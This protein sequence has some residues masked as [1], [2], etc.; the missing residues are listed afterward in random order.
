MPAHS[1]VL[2]A[3]VIAPDVL[4]AEAAAKALVITGSHTG[5]DWLD[6]D[7]SLAGVIIL[8]SGEALYSRRMDQFLWR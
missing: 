7:P 4:T 6:A 1:D 3:T 5:L 2:A 8:Q